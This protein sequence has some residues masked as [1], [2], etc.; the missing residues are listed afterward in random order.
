MVELAAKVSETSSI[1]VLNSASDATINV[2]VFTVILLAAPTEISTFVI[3]SLI[4]VVLYIVR[5]IPV[6][7]FPP[8]RHGFVVV[9]PVTFQEIVPWVISLSVAYPL[10]PPV[11]VPSNV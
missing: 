8:I 5:S 2:R 3:A 10:V 7:E 11:W 4:A 1:T 9:L 6:R